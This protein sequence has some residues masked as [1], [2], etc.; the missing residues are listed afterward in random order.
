VALAVERAQRASSE[1]FKTKA[2]LR[3][4]WEALIGYFSEGSPYFD[5]DDA[6]V[7][8]ETTEKAKPCKKP[9]VKHGKK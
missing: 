8:W 7:E 1:G 2:A 9:A 6:I 4:N 3:K 5:L